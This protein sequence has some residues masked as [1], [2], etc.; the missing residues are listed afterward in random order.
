LTARRRQSGFTLI[1][2]LIGLM[3]VA[4]LLTSIAVATHASLNSYNEN[5]KFAALNQTTRVLLARMRREIRTAEAVDYQAESGNVVI[6]PPASTGV[7]E[8]RYEYDYETQRLYYHQTIG[9]QTTKQTVLGGNSLVKPMSLYATYETV[10]VGEVTCT[11][12]V[13]VMLGL[14]VDGEYHTVTCS[15]APRRNQSY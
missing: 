11:R 5:A 8:I 6:S 13:V 4:L 3:L 7:D 9:G 12:R 1:E 10:Q 14:E 2:L 15:A